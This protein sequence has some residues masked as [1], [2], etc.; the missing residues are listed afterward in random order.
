M[1]ESNTHLIRQLN[2]AF[3]ARPGDG[4]FFTRGIRAEG[5]YFVAA[6]LLAVTQFEAFTPDNDPYGEHDFGALGVLGRRVF[7]KIDYFD[8]TGEHASADPAN[9][10]IT[11]RIL[12]VLL[13]SEY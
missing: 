1:T 4:W 13:A 2:D 8:K 11:K 10:A 3:R 7:W 12:T 5:P 9:P 6:A